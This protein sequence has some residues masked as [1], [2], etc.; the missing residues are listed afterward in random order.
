MDGLS[1]ATA[2]QL[3]KAMRERDISCVE[4]VQAHLDR[5]ARFNPQLNAIVTLDAENALARAEEADAALARGSSWG[6]LHGVPITIKD[7]LCTAGLRTTSGHPDL[8]NHIPARDATVVARLRAAGAIILGKTNLPTLARDV[9]TDNPVFGR[10]NNPWN[11]DCTPGGSTGGGAAAVAAGLTPLEIGSDIG[12]S[13]RVPAHYCGVCALKPTDRRVPTIGH[14][15]E[16]PGRMR[17]LRHMQTVGPLARSVEDLATT[18]RIIAGADSDDPSAPPVPLLSDAR[19]SLKQIHIFW[20][21]KFGNLSITTEARRAIG[22]VAG[23][24]ASLRYQVERATC[25][26]DFVLA[27]E[28]WGELLQTELAASLTEQ[29]EAERERRLGSLRNPD[30]PTLRGAA[31][32]LNATVRQYMETLSRRDRIIA[33]LDNF[34]G[35]NSILLCPVT[36]GT[37][38]PHCPVGAPID[39]DGAKVPY[40]IGSLGFCSPFNLT[41]HPSVVLPLRLSSAGLPIGIQVVGPRWSDL[42]LLAIAQELAEIIGP[43]PRPPGY[44]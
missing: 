24:L 17:G 25:I 35:E 42:S 27:W 6:P 14:I 15:P 4:V 18:L 30:E 2:Q 9:Q 41:G 31:R 20:T 26:T 39:V 8:A 23:D 38:I 40:W 5:I 1:F 13:V 22:T 12:G 11:L 10:T 16:M 37:A 36:V 7:S 43:F 29:E 28:T 34:L 19:F 32:R 44:E 33:A 3:V 21:D